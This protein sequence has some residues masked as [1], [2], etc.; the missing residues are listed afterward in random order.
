MEIKV[1]VVI[2]TFRRVELL[3]RCVNA[4]L[5]QHC[6]EAFEVI[7]VTDG[8]DRR[9][10]D[11]FQSSHYKLRVISLEE[12][13]GPAAARNKGWK[14]AKGELIVFTD[15]DCIPSPGLLSTYWD[16]YSQTDARPGA[17]TG[18]IVVPQKIKPTDHERNTGLLEQAEF[19]TA[20]CACTKSAL[21][22]VDGFDEAFTMAWREDSDLHFKFLLAAIP[23]RHVRD[24][25]V[26]HPVRSAPWGV[27]LREQKKSLF[28]A[29]LYKKFPRTYRE[30]KITRPLWTYYSTVAFAL[31]ALPA[32]ANGQRTL[33]GFFVAGWSILAIAFIRKRLRGTSTSI[34]HVAEMILTS[35][36]IP[37]LSIYW[38]VF[39]SIRYKKLLL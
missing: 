31:L 12:K 22:G 18:R 33:A 36:A 38:T 17:F 11:F 26:V 9:T 28:N 25:V 30:K 35:V 7:I 37:F 21:I 15:D 34:S 24:A 32:L 16:A 27:S 4:L 2:P 29:L 5:T 20:N 19:V 1:S 8:P 23:I 13:R 14:T 39:G 10:T 3:E 6:P